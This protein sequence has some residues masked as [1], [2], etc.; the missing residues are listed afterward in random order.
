MTLHFSRNTLERP[1]IRTERRILERIYVGEMSES[2][3]Q[4]RCCL[5]LSC[6]AFRLYFTEILRMV[7]R[8][9]LL[10][11]DGMGSVGTAAC[12]VAIQ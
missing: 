3:R 1:E 11:S 5:A 10:R 9:W 12:P 2:H 7:R 4:D 6:A 8:W